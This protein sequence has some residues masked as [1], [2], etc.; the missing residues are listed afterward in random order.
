MLIYFPVTVSWRD[1]QKHCTW[2]S[3]SFS[4]SN[5]QLL[6]CGDVVKSSF[7][8]LICKASLFVNY[9]WISAAEVL[10]Q[11]YWTVACNFLE[12]QVWHFLKIVTLLHLKVGKIVFLILYVSVDS[13][14]VWKENHLKQMKPGL[15]KITKTLMFT[16]RC[17]PQPASTNSLSSLF[18]S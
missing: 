4:T 13:Y 14:Y 11:K 17:C 12:P 18:S 6:S 2:F 15:K 3:I 5:C 10:K 1:P 9:T 16:F 8:L 7:S